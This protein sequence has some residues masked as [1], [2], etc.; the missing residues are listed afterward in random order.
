MADKEV[1]EYDAVDSGNSTI[2]SGDGGFPELMAR[3]AVNNSAR[4][5]QAALRRYYNDPEWIVV[6]IQ[7]PDAGDIGVFSWV[8]ATQFQINLSGVDLRPYFDVGRIIRIVDGGGVGVDLVTQVVSRSYSDPLTTVD[9]TATDSMNVAA[10][11]AQ[12]FHSSIIRKLALSD[13]DAQFF[14]PATTTAAGINAAIAAADAAGGGT[15]LLTESLYTLEAQI[16][17]GASVGRVRLFGAG[18]EVFLRQ[19]V[20]AGIDPLVDLS[21]TAEPVHL[22]NIQFDMNGNAGTIVEIDGAL[23]PRIENCVFVDGT[24]H[25][26]FTSVTTSNAI[27]SECLFTEY[28]GHAIRSTAVSDTHSGIISSCRIQGVSTTD[29]NAAGIKLAGQWTIDGNTITSIGKSSGTPRGIWLWNEQA[30]AGGR[31]SVVSNNRIDGDGDTN[32]TMIEIGGDYVACSGNRINGPTAGIG[33]HING[34]AAGQT[35]LDAVVSGNVVV[36][37]T[38]ISINQRVKNAAV[39]GNTCEP[40]AGLT[41]IECDGDQCLIANNICEG[42]AVG[43]EVQTNSADCTISGNVID[44]P[45]ADGVLLSGICGDPVVMGNRFLGGIVDAVDV[46]AGV[47]NAIIKDNDIDSAVTNPITNASTTTRHLRNDE[48][49]NV[50]QRY[51]DSDTD[52]WGIATPID[53][54]TITALDLP[55]NDAIGTYHI[56]YEHTN[57]DTGSAGRGGRFRVH[58]GPTGDLTDP[59]VHT[60]STL[61]IGGTETEIRDMEEGITFAVTDALDTKFGLSVIEMG[62]V[63]GTGIDYSIEHFFIEKITE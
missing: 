9:I 13:S 5:V 46:A 15:V 49:I 56:W 59:I 18:P 63:G 20:A 14:I 19:D 1:Y 47:T 3:A 42:G 2:P 43:V 17:F 22:E 33:I 7:G 21:A 45:S 41:A 50:R 58:V 35:I 60:S 61:T 31:R 34:T 8:S 55:G 48:D 23:R 4:K 57:G 24:D 40:A 11:D 10:S 38:P 25:I 26:V 54:D 44:S 53:V 12:V 29:A 39:T 37:G 27:I 6:R 32:G 36:Q 52:G 51:A 16:V 62:G 30:N 28:T